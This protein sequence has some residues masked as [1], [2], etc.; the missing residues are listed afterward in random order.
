MEKNG[1]K[2]TKVKIITISVTVL[3][4]F[5]TV[6]LNLLI[7]KWYS[8]DLRYKEGAY[9][10]F[11]GRAV[12]SVEIK[13]YGHKV[14]KSIKTFV[15]FDA[16]ILDI[17]ISEGRQYKI[18]NGGIGENRVKLEVERLV[19]KDKML[20]FFTVEKAQKSPFIEQV[21]HSEGLGRTGI[22]RYWEWLILIPLYL[23]APALFWIFWELK[24]KGALKT[25][26]ANIEKVIELAFESAKSGDTENDFKDKLDST[27]VRTQFRKETLKKIGF[28]VFNKAPSLEDE[29]P[30]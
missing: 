16:R 30:F 8:P 3:V 5:L 6:V 27:L 17:Q 7:R 22:P 10:L 21:E 26:Y 28:A 12:T 4:V 20:I 1:S 13:N 9:Y 23:F 19:P 14:A 2:L 25:H 24:M 11:E 29:I 15:I 18:I